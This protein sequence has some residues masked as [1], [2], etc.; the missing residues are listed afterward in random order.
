[1]SIELAGKNITYLNLSKTG[2]E[3]DNAG[4]TD[5]TCTVKLDF[6][7]SALLDKQDDYICAVTRF[8]IPL[9]EIPTILKCSFKIYTYTDQQ[10]YDGT[11][12]LVQDIP[13]FR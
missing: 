6:R 1:M 13:W 9:S 3:S 7:D 8:S 4:P 12:V 5:Q 11:P 10:M 2:R